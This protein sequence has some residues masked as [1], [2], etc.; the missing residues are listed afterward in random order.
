MESQPK[1]VGVAAVAALQRVLEELP[2]YR[3]SEVSRFRAIQLLSPQIHALRS[4]G[5]NW[6]AIATLL[7]EQGI[8]VTPAVLRKYLWD[9]PA[10]SAAKK[11]SNAPRTRS[12]SAVTKMEP[13]AVVT[14]RR[15][16]PTS[17]PSPQSASVPVSNKAESVAPLAS[18]PDGARRS[19]FVPR[20]DSEVI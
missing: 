19:A 17:D 1:R 6:T 5:Y 15:T 8:T 13:T 2:E 11:R 18:R 14:E 12:A 20:K 7:S 3:A 4:K 9:A 10:R 16:S